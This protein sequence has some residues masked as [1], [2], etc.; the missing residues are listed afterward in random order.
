MANDPLETPSNVD[1]SSHAAQT[2]AVV[3]LGSNSFH[4]VLARIIAKDVQILLREKIKVRLARG[5]DEQLMLSDEA[6][7][8]GLDTLK[9]FAH[10]LKGFHPDDVSILGTYT[11]RAAKNSQRFIEQAK[12]ILPYPIKLITGQEEARLIYHGV[13]HSMYFTENRLVIDIGGGS[14]EFALGRHF[15]PLALTSRNI[16]CVNLSEQFFADGKISKKRFEKALLKAERHI[17]PIVK[18]Y[19]SIDWQHCVGT[20]GTVSA[21]LQAA[22]ENDLTEHYLTLEAL[23]KLKDKLLSYRHVN[24]IDLAGISDDRKSVI[25][26]GLAVMLAAF[27]MLDID[28]LEYCDKALREGAL[29]EMEDRLEHDDIR[30][31]SVDS[32]ISRLSVDVEHVQRVQQ[33]SQH[34]LSQLVNQSPLKSIPEA[35][36]VLHWATKLHE[37]GLHINS[38]GSHKHSAYIVSQSELS[39][40][41]QEL[42]RLVTTLVRFQRKKIDIDELPEFTMYAWSDVRKLMAIFRIAVLLN[43]KRQD[44]FLPQ[45]TL[46]I[47]DNIWQLLFANNWL[48]EHALVEDNLVTEVNQ[49]KK[50]DLLL[51][52]A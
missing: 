20:S 35:E 40:F 9:I 21:L 41:D 17:Q 15:Q 29:Y 1:E 3:D 52:I 25:I 6:I 28:Q 16:G 48:D 24:D 27:L 38:S 14:T 46:T 19:K 30:E 23:L 4:L 31:R 37:I 44:D 10:T 2:V 33:T 22:Q 18:Q 11:L 45:V 39:G 13:A 12:Q 43:Q 49:L 47:E 51:Q 32:L 26:S 5:L 50:I 7:Q 42:Q 34:L 8:R 36:K